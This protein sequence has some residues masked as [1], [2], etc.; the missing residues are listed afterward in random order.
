MSCS[1]FSDLSFDKQ[2]D[3]VTKMIKEHGLDPSSSTLGVLAVHGQVQQYCGMPGGA[4]VG[5]K[6]TKNLD[7]AIE[8]GVN[9]DS[10]TK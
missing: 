5:A 1:E 6:A 2:N 4:L 10:L 8:N 7:S 9:W 3:A